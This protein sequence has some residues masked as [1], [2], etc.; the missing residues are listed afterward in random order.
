MNFTLYLIA[1]R[2]KKIE[3]YPDDFTAQRFRDAC[4]GVSGARLSVWPQD[5]VMY[6]AY[7]CAMP[8]SDVFGLVLGLKDVVI[9]RPKKL[10]EVLSEFVSSQ[11]PKRGNVI[12]YGED[13]RLNFAKQKF[14]SDTD[15]YFS[16]HRELEKLLT[17]KKNVLGVANRNIA[18][19]RAPSEKLTFG[20]SASD[21]AIM[22]V[23]S[24]G[25]S[26]VV[27]DDDTEAFGG[28][29]T[30]TVIQGLREQISQRDDSIAEKNKQIQSLEHSRKQYR[31]VIGLLGV[32]LL[33]A[34]GLYTLNKNLKD[35]EESL[36]K[37]NQ[38]IEHYRSELIAANFDI[39]RRIDTIGALR[40]DILCLDSA[41]NGLSQAKRADS[42][43]AIR[44]LNERDSRI[45]RLQD[46]LSLAVRKQ[47]QS[48]SEAEK[49]KRRL[50]NLTTRMS[51]YPFLVKTISRSGNTLYINYSAASDNRSEIEIRCYSRNGYLDKSTH[52]M[53]VEAGE[54]SCSLSDV[55]SLH[56]AD[57]IVMYY[58]GRIIGGGWF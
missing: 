58:N 37:A 12:C 9:E 28:D 38:S 8:E 39:E 31:F 30:Y 6:Y 21:Y 25:D 23:L 26:W 51:A 18:G 52:N 50:R 16:L 4:A 20:L 44:M 49:A 56:K 36:D 35:T 46:D 29:H 7:A 43:Y 33:G 10:F 1:Q 22:R 27:I 32:I 45:T 2:G 17:S 5:G 55:K 40:F 42:L 24:D 57:Y 19:R 34:I 53:S 3:Q 47:A 48:Q 14:A 13:G 41:Y 11:M 15:A 54:H